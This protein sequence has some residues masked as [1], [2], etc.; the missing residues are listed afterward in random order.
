MKGGERPKRQTI[1]R[2]VS[3]ALD[4]FLAFGFLQSIVGV[5][6]YAALQFQVY[7]VSPYLAGDQHHL[8]TRDKTLPTLDRGFVE[9]YLGAVIQKLLNVGLRLRYLF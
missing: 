4:E 1:R 7:E 2:E 6:G 8:Q 5:L 9:V 3:Y